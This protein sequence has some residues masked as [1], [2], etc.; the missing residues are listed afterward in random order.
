M[1][2]KAAIILGS[3]SPFRRELLER[4]QIPF[5]TCSP[6]VDETPLKR[7]SPKDLSL[8]LSVLKARA[9]AAQHPHCVVISCDQVLELNGRPVG[10]PGNFENAFKQLSEMSGQTV[11]FHSAMTVIDAKGNL[12]STVVPT[13]IR[14]RNLPP[15]G[16]REYLERE[17]PFNCA[18]SAKIEK[19]GIALVAECKSDD[20]TAIIGLPLIELTT[21]LAQAGIHVLPELN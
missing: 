14:M 8:R 18:G 16:I 6:D 13:F 12:Q 10:K 15:E 11:T 17:K 3:S 19:L 5:T 2:N 20:P 21:M 4:L 9:V 1:D 7:E